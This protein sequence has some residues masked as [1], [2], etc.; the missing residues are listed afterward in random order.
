VA[1]SDSVIAYFTP[2]KVE[3][4]SVPSGS[5]VS[6]VNWPGRSTGD[7]P[8]ARISKDG[9]WMIAYT[10]GKIGC[11]SPGLELAWELPVTKI[12]I[13]AAISGSD[14]LVAILENER[15]TGIH[16]LSVY[17]ISTGSLVWSKEMV[18]DSKEIVSDCSGLSFEGDFITWVTQ[19][20][21][22]WGEG[23]VNSQTKTF[24]FDLKQRPSET[25]SF[26]AFPGVVSLAARGDQLVVVKAESG[27][28]GLIEV[29]SR[30]NV[31]DK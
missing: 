15:K 8:I 30:S 21:K 3:F 29:E 5:V 26:M 12:F 4:L 25:Q 16:V 27:L 24:V 6:T 23:V 17:N 1:V 14:G 31:A 19:Y 28:S 18:I 11:F 7:Y 10:Y 13:D 20:Y 2:T 22:F 9:G